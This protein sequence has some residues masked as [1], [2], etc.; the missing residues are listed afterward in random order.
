MISSLS[1][2]YCVSTRAARLVSVLCRWKGYA[3]HQMTFHLA[4]L[5]LDGG[6]RL[7]KEFTLFDD[8]CC[9]GGRRRRG[10]RVE[11]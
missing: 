3:T 8:G 11:R 7:A 9:G 1:W 4:D 6:Q 2:A 5:D 10:H